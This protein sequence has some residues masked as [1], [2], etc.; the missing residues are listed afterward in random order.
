MKSILL[1]ALAAT[2]FFAAG[3]ATAGRPAVAAEPDAAPERAKPAYAATSALV[4][5]AARAVLVQADGKIVFGGFARNG[6]RTGYGLARV[7][8]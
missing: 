5:Q 3:S 2:A 6:T 1:I 7:L 4:A 8:P